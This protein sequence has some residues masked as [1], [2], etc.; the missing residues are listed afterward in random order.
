MTEIRLT[1]PA[2]STA[3]RPPHRPATVR[4]AVVV[5]VA[6]AALTGVVATLAALPFV[7]GAAVMVTSAVNNFEALPASLD[8]APLPQQTTILYA[9]GSVLAQ[10]SGQ[11]RI[12]VPLAAIPP[13]MREAI[14]SVEDSRF[15]EHH[16]V[17]VRGLLRALATNSSSGAV[18]EGASTLT[19]QYVKNVL[20][21]AAINADQVAAARGHSATRKLREIR[22]ALALE[23]KY[24][25][26][27]IL[28]KYLNI[29]YFG[30][31]AYGVEAASQ[32][33]FGIPAKDMSLEQ[34]ATLAGIVQQPTGFDPL[35]HPQASQ[36]RR[37]VVLRKMASQGYITPAQAQGAIAIPMWAELNATQLHASG[38]TSTTNPYFC[39]Y[40]LH[41]I[42]TD[43]IFGATQDQRN[44]F[45][46]MGGYTIRTTMQPQAQTA[47]TTAVTAAIP[48]DDP[49]QRA[50]AITMVQPGTGDIV[51]M[52]QNRNWGLS[53]IGNTTYNFNVNRANGGTIGMQAGS[54]FKVFTLAAALQQGLPPSTTIYSPNPNTFTGFVNCTT[55]TPF[56][57]LTV[58]NSTGA[59]TFDMRTGTAYSINTY[60]MG[61]EQMTG[62]CAPADIA[63]SM[64][65]YR[66]NGKPLE[67]V[68]SFTLGT[69]EVTPL[70]M[71]EAYATFANHGSYC[72]PRAILQMINREGKPVAIPPVSCKQVITRD[73][74][75][76]VTALLTGVIDGPIGGRTGAPMSLPDRPA[77]GK[78]GTTNDSAAV[79]FDGFTPD[80]AASVWVGD[81]RGGYGFPMKDVTINGKYYA[82]V[83]G[84]TLPGPIW[85]QA[86]V[87]ALQ[88]TMP[89]AF[90]LQSSFGLTAQRGVWTGQSSAAPKPT[91]SPAPFVFSNPQQ[92]APAT[93]TTTQ[94]TTTQ[95]TTTQTTTTQTTP[96]APAAN[97]APVD[98]APNQAG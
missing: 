62:I 10:I 51:A 13:I 42:A 47:A 24:S 94:T 95:T 41:T 92:T 30:A 59:G 90:D 35:L 55:H 65:V 11:D 1:V 45:L 38:C 81:P 7:G 40:V 16:G 73:V 5:F 57:P 3:N 9:D 44:A 66:G 4:R 91:S 97:P 28:D 74:A 68:P 78:T 67:R 21:N 56:P 77:A 39:Q 76:S 26:G 6:L 85:K 54:T 88:G 80:L 61:L 86:M 72:A 96:G 69:Q 87:G 37:D 22:L 79:W 15:L 48:I 20:V 89:A 71:A 25:K 19:M 60:F 12:E 23:N 50:A 36:H 27:Q 49:S 70:Q 14:V 33:Y 46:R 98:G 93:P 43:P 82:Q 64:G 17:D 84:S 31:G 8:A 52:A 18:T 83:F 63:E 34:A 75:D 2:M 29:A 58:H 32:R 53:G